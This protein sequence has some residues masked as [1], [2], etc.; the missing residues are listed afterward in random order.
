VTTATAPGPTAPALGE[1][2]ERGFVVLRALFTEK[3]SLVLREQI[4]GLMREENP[5]G[6]PRRRF[7]RWQGV[8]RHSEFWSVIMHEPLVQAARALAAAGV[9]YAHNSELQ[10]NNAGHLWHR[11]SLDQTAPIGPDWDD[12]AEP[13]RL[14]RAC[15]YLQSHRE[16]GFRFGAVPG[17]HKGGRRTLAGLAAD[18]RT[19]LH[20]RLRLRPPPRD[21]RRRPLPLVTMRPGWRARLRA[22]TPEWVP[23]DL[24]DC[25][26]LHQR[27]VHSAS[28]VHGPHYAIYFS[29]GPEDTHTRRQWLHYRHQRPD[30]PQGR[31]PRELAHRL[32]AADL[33]LDCDRAEL[34]GADA[35]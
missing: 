33:L 14:V 17:S 22:A 2:Q 28:E 16:S 27:L 30:R 31:L 26:L 20:R 3:E 32:A 18:A 10:A 1:F 8:T 29:Y 21:P 35:G 24:G 12:T 34:A 25:V 15:I 7:D 6:D 4:D 23:V 19:A 11:D 9:R 5:G 13:Y